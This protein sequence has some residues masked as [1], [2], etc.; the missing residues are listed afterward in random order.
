VKAILA[1]ANIIFW[2]GV[3]LWLPGAVVLNVIWGWG[4][5]SRPTLGFHAFLTMGTLFVPALGVVGYLSGSGGQRFIGLAVMLGL[6]VAALGVT[7]CACI[8]LYPDY[9]QQG[10]HELIAALMVLP[11]V[12]V[13][14]TMAALWKR[15]KLFPKAWL[16]CGAWAALLLA[17]TIY[18]FERD[19]DMA[20]PLGASVTRWERN[21]FQDYSNYCLRADH[22]DAPGAAH[23]AT[24]IG[25]TRREPD[26]STAYG[27][28][29]PLGSGDVW[30]LDERQV[31]NDREQY[32]SGFAGCLTRMTW[33]ND[34]LFVCDI[35]DW[36][37]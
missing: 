34:S 23:Y 24:S 36:G 35:C 7:A 26:G 18:A 10:P 19:L 31:Q 4:G 11:G 17:G 20:L 12:V 37:I 9:P 3:A 16:Y 21:D 15:L 22:V 8:A 14:V 33:V 30:E 13:P 25:L 2:V 29:T 5:I 32:P 1:S 28:W 27:P 6:G